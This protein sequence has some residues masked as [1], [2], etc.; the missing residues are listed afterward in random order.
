MNRWVIMTDGSQVLYI[1]A[2]NYPFPVPLA[3][4]ASSQS[5]F[6]TPAGR[7]EVLARRMGRNELLAIDASTAI[8]NAEEIFYKRPPSGHTHQYT[9][10]S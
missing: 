10:L 3:K 9:T 8:A 4:N 1:G 5:F 6:N 2:D 7:D